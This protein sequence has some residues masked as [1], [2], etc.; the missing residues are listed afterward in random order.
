MRHTSWLNCSDTWYRPAVALLILSFNVGHLSAFYVVPGSNCTDACSSAFTAY[1]TNGSDI[2][3]H[4]TDYNSTTIGEAF[5]ICVSC[6]IQ[7]P[8]LNPYTVQTDVG[9]ALCKCK[10]SCPPR[11]KATGSMADLATLDRQHEVHSRL[12]S[13]RFSQ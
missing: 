11:P 9:W 3:C 2:V 10:L 13:I 5:Q 12:V 1:T 7:S 4:D 8:A 6:E